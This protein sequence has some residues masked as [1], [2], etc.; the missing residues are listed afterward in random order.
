MIEIGGGGGRCG[1]YMQMNS[2]KEN[3]KDGVK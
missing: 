1:K 2:R 3:K